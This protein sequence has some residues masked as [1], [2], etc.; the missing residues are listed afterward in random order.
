MS[1]FMILSTPGRL[2]MTV[3]LDLIPAFY[4]KYLFVLETNILKVIG[5]LLVAAIV[6]FETHYINYNLKDLPIKMKLTNP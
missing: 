2:A 3:M 6:F 4:T 1:D 5:V